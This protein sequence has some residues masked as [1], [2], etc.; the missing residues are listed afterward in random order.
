MFFPELLLGPL[1]LCYTFVDPPVYGRC[2][3]TYPDGVPVPSRYV[4]W[5]RHVAPFYIEQ[6]A[7]ASGLATMFRLFP[8]RAKKPAKT[9]AEFER[10]LAASMASTAT[11]PLV[12]VV[13]EAVSAKE[14]LALDAKSRT[15]LRSVTVKK[16][17]LRVGAHQQSALAHGAAAVS[18]PS[19][20]KLI[21]LGRAFIRQVAEI[22]QTADGSII[23]KGTGRLKV[24]RLFYGHAPPRLRIPTPKTPL[25]P[26]SLLCLALRILSR[27]PLSCLPL[28]TQPHPLSPT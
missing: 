23:T 13:C 7:A 15:K 26:C 17:I 8:S 21:K 6:H 25:P 2:I 11:F 12:Q 5:W 10:A 14:I 4:C 24:K 16:T 27:S 22:R 19:K 9:E 3:V 20:Q 28:W 1:D 18:I